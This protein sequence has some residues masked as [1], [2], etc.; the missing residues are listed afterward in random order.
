M[1]IVTLTDRIKLYERVFGPGRIDR[2]CRNFDVRCP[3]CAPKDPSKKKLSIF[4]ADD[5]LHCWSCGFKAHTLVP[6]IK[7]FCSR[8]LLVEYCERFMPVGTKH[9]RCWTISL[10]SEKPVLALPGDFRMLVAANSRDPD[11]AAMRRY[12][13]QRNVNEDDMWRYRLGC[14]DEPAWRRRIIVPSFDAAGNVNWYV[15]RAIDER[16]KPKYEAPAGDRKHIIFNEMDVDWKLPLVLCEGTFDMMKC[17]ENAVPLL[18]SD[19]NEQSSLFN[20]ILVHE[21]S[22]LLALDADIRAT[23][24]LKHAS[25]LAEYGIDV[26]I[27]NVR[28]DPG[29]MSKKEFTV[30]RSRAE[31]FDWKLAFRD[32]LAA[33]TMIDL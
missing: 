19:L 12:L 25:K 23:K 20:C 26:S 21:T 16:R 7:K 10:P 9:Q 30:A 22:V 5:R 17:G 28:S 14:S 3:I 31:Q 1:S 2:A 32:R 15:G 27:I 4:V 29:S 33:A 13:E 24:T 6:L 18:G 11:V 8:E